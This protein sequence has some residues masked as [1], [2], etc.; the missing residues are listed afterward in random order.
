MNYS[1]Q[2]GCIKLIEADG[3]NIYATKDFNCK[4]VKES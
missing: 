3:K 1:I 4:F 2:Q